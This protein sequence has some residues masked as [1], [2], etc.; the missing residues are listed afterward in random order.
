MEQP[1]SVDSSRISANPRD[2]QTA[3]QSV[4]DRAAC[5]TVSIRARRPQP[6]EQRNA[7][8]A[9]FSLR[10]TVV[11]GSGVV[12]DSSGLILTNEHVVQGASEITI[13]NFEG[14]SY[15]AT[16]V[17]SDARSDLAV[18][19]TDGGSWQAPEWGDAASLT[20]GQWVIALGNP[21]GLGVDGVASASVGIVSNLN[22][23]LPG[24]GS[25]DDRLYHDMIQVTASI[26]PG[27]S[28]GPL[29]NLDGSLIGIVTAMH[30]RAAADEGVGFAIPLSPAKRR[31]I[32]N[33]RAGQRI[34][35][36]YLG[37]SVL[38]VAAESDRSP[39]LVVDAVE[40]KGPSD[41]AGVQAGDVIRELNGELAADLGRFAELVGACR[42]GDEV[43][44]ALLRDDKELT[45]RIRVDRRQS[46]R[47]ACFRGDAIL[48][49]GAR[50]N[51]LTSR[52]RV[53]EARDGG[54][55]GVIVTDVVRGSAADRA[56]LR[57]GDV[58]VKLGDVSIAGLDQFEQNAQ[59]F[60]GEV[61]LSLRDR[62]AIR[63][64]P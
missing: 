59:Q 46:L 23:R 36:G 45:I 16:V 37:L 8:D 38:P 31:I 34:Q 53:A 24:L 25:G 42:A 6:L 12:L 57:V 55:T 63:I 43:S 51:D 2:L 4:I 49:R 28:G 39:R 50:L 15:A 22:R 41:R 26:H 40:S 18:L 35:Y 54:R 21:F 56:G 20:R 52:S 48:W 9:D 5:S 11:N 44:L 60:T 33:L 61:E 29:F 19:R 14:V 3:F 10:A 30:T 1:G 17:S 62:E 47:V 58:V 7:S 13:I 32:E 64:A 27:N